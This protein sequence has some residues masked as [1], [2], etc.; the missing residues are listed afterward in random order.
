MIER[1]LAAVTWPVIRPDLRLEPGMLALE[2]VG[3]GS[4][5]QVSVHTPN[6]FAANPQNSFEG[7]E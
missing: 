2:A 7:G 6:S 1:P 5:S 4:L 3:L